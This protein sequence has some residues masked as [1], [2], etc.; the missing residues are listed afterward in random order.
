VL[1]LLLLLLPLLLLP[2]LLLLLL[3]PPLLLLLLIMFSSS[4]VLSAASFSFVLSAGCSAS[5]ASPGIALKITRGPRN[6]SGSVG[7]VP[8]AKGMISA[9]GWKIVPFPSRFTTGARCDT[10][11]DAPS[12]P[13][14]LDSSGA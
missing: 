5:R 11:P 2:L 13:G 1:Q 10:K 14:F 7:I 3:L 12:G 9:S 4:S 8:L 6:P